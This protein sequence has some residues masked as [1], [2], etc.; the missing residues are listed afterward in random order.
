MPRAS[1]ELRGVSFAYPGRD[2]R[3]FDD[4]DLVIEA[5]RSIAIVGANGAGKT[6]LVKMLCGLLDP[7]AGA[8]VVDGVPL[9]ALDR[10]AWQGRVAAIFQD[11]VRYPFSARDNIV[12]GRPAAVPG[13]LDRAIERTMAGAAIEG[14]P[15]GLETP[16]AREFGGLDL[17]G[18]QWQ[19][20]AL[21]R[22]MYAVERGAGVLI[23]DE[24]TA[25]L[26]IRAEAELFDRFLELT[27][28]LTT[29]LIS[30]RFSSVRHA[31]RIVVLE[32]GRIVEDG[33]HA[34]LLAAGGRYAAMFRLQAQHFD[35][36]DA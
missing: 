1:I 10:P 26:D 27:A 16:L 34:D 11:F 20:V 22:A 31:D 18:G 13:A 9:S 17:S 28:G 19:R 15:G 3:V 12:L 6:T 2:A 23:L 25:H 4:L 30:H 32:D 29:I 24:P 35:A 8:I 33:T 5:G 36:P 21:A 14:L 7:D